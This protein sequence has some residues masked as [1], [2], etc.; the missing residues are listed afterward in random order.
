MRNDVPIGC[1]HKSMQKLMLEA[2][3]VV[4]V[5]VNGWPTSTFFPHRH[6]CQ[7]KVSARFCTTYLVMK[8]KKELLNKRYKICQKKD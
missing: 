5:V 8:V 7:L 4:V 3:A 1:Y 6:K 2:T